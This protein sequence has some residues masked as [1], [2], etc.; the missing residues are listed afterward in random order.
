MPGP[1]T[2][3]TSPLTGAQGPGDGVAGSPAGQEAPPR[4]AQRRRRLWEEPPRRGAKRALPAPAPRPTHTSLAGSSLASTT[5]KCSE[6]FLAMLGWRGRSR[7]ASW[8]RCRRSAGFLRP[9]ASTARRFRAGR[10]LARAAAAPDGLSSSSPRAHAGEVSRH[11]G[12]PVRPGAERA[13]L[14]ESISPARCPLLAACRP[15]SGVGGGYRWPGRTSGIGRL[16]AAAR[17]TCLTP[18]RLL[19]GACGV[20]STQGAGP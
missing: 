20:P 16:L 6:V 14:V 11:A 8:L 15:G 10:L 12:E 17:G 19:E 1:P 7:A 4:R 2:P 5:R 3:P 9:G 13:S 18:A